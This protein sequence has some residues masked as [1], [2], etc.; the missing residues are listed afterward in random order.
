M[1]DRVGNSL[2]RTIEDIEGFPRRNVNETTLN[3]FLERVAKRLRRVASRLGRKTSVQRDVHGVSHTFP[4]VGTSTPS[5]AT[6]AGQS[7][8]RNTHDTFDY[9]PEEIGMS[10]LQ[11]ASSTQQTQPRVQRQRRPKKR[12]TP[13]TDALGKGKTRS[14]KQ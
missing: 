1:F 12:Y 5:V 13:G 10:Q 3:T 4:G 8:S 2:R 14:S 7:S 6:S 11:D 9:G